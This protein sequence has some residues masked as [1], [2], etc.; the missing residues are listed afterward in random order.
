VTASE[1]VV[2]DERIQDL[3]TER[4]AKLVQL[5]REQKMLDEAVK[6]RNELEQARSIVQNVAEELQRKAHERLTSVVTKC[7]DSVFEDPYE[8]KIEFEKKRGKD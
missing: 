7:L 8:F 5:E 1:L 6:E 4:R 3:N 2:I